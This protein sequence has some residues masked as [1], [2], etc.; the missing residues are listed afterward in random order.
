MLPTLRRSIAPAQRRDKTA[1][2]I[3]LLVTVLEGRPSPRSKALNLEQVKAL[4]TAARWS[5]SG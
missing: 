4:L 5:V 3:A 1:W 2:N